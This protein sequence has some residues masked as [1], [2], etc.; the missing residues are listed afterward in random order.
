[1]TTTGTAG[2]GCSPDADRQPGE[3]ATC[4]SGTFDTG[5]PTCLQPSL[6]LGMLAC[7]AV[8]VFARRYPGLAA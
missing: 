7:T 5:S 3:W 8:V 6:I 2:G 1:M 4:N